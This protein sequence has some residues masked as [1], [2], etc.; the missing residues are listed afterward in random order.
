MFTSTLRKPRSRRPSAI[1]PTHTP[2]QSS[3]YAVLNSTIIRL[4]IRRNPAWRSAGYPDFVRTE[5]LE[6]LGGIYLDDDA[7]ILRELRHLYRLGFGN[8]VEVQSDG[9][10]CP[11][12][13]MSTPHN[14]DRISR[15]AR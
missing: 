8:S 9:Q 6:R 2:R 15:S 3:I 7:Y 14:N 5:V 13:I 1:P 11:A 4:Q 12:V 10:I